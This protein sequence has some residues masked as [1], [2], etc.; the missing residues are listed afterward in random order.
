M[1]R[2]T[3]ELPDQFIFTAELP[4]RVSDLNYGGHVGN[5]A[6][7][8]IMQEARVRY[9]RH[10]GFKDEISFHGSIGQIIT[11]AA[12][13]YKSE[14][15]LGDVLLVQIA[16][17]EFSKYGFDMLYYLENKETGKEVARGK[18][19]IVCFDYGKRKIAVIPAELLK[20]LHS[21]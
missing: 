20:A 16:V 9:Y 4:V 12:I 5:D 18:T 1:P 19:N 3:I 15:F 10:L 21:K 17:T 14:A 6:I 7:L 13:Q 2:I 8:T 11:D